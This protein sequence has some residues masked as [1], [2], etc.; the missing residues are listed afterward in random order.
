[1]PNGGTDL[2]PLLEGCGFPGPVTALGT[3]WSQE[4][5]CGDLGRYKEH[6]PS[7]HYSQAGSL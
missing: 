4:A 6:G 1:M 2:E 7:L 3:D 5:E